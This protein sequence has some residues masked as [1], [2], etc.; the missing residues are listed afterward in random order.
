MNL[1][2]VVS[3]LSIL[4]KR[5]QVTRF[6]PNWAQQEFLT[7]AQRQFSTTGRV[8]I[9]V[10]KARQLGISTLTE[11]CLF[12]LCFVFDEFRATVIAHEA[13]ASKNLLAMTDRYW[14]T[15]PYRH[16]YTTKRHASNHME[17]NETHSSLRVATAGNKETGRSATN[18]GLHMSRTHP[19][20]PSSPT[21]R[22]QRTS[23]RTSRHSRTTQPRH[24]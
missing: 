13:E 23:R 2:P 16:L 14:R 8:R 5:G 20:R 3:Q 9:I 1:T 4:T 15:Y 24:V 11:A 22:P 21:R 6:Q 12:S 17:W 10:L 19:R 7:E 18:R